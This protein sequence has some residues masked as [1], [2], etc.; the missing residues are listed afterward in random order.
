VFL[1]FGGGVYLLLW[2]YGLV[3]ERHEAADFAPFTI[4]LNWLDLGLAVVMIGAG[5]GITAIER[6]TGRY[7]P[8]NAGG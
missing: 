8:D 7:P 4:A 2:F 6:A 3:A 5:F 1:T